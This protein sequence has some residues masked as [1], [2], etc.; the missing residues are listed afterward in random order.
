MPMVLWYTS[1][2][3]QAYVVYVDTQY[4]L[5]MTATAEE[6]AVVGQWTSCSFAAVS[7]GGGGWG[8]G[9]LLLAT[10]RRLY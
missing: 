7:V 2:S 3:I 9:L 1:A 8:V 4:S 6:A 5:G 10:C